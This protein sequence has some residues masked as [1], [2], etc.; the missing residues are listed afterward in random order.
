MSN[1]TLAIVSYLTIIGWIIAYVSHKGQAQRS[2]LVQYHLEQS[3]GLFIVFVILSIVTSAIVFIVPAIAIVAT[4]VGIL[5]LIL[6]VMGIIN[7]ANEVCKPV[8]L[9]GKFFERKMGFLA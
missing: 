4:I 2:Q 6:L 3:L 1:K 9:V 8:P 5:E 7:A